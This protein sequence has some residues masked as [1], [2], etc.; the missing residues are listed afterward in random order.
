MYLKITPIF[1]I[2]LSGC[3]FTINPD[4][5]HA[6]L[7]G[8]SYGHADD[9]TEKPSNSRWH[10]Y[11]ARTWGTSGIE[12][13]ITTDSELISIQGSGISDHLSETLGDDIVDKIGDSVAC[14]LQPIQPKCIDP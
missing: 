11:A 14:A 5:L 1:L 2:M 13:E 3:A 8:T 10:T 4:G 12:G 7:G 6:V 9:Q